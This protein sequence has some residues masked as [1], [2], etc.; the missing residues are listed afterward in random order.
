MILNVTTHDPCYRGPGLGCM[1]G[2]YKNH[3]VPLVVCLLW[4]ASCGVP[5]VACLLQCASCGVPLVL[6]QLV[7]SIF[8]NL[9]DISSPFLLVSS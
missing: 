8:R 4:C 5:L 3:G 2:Q 1:D 6:I 7:S 9:L